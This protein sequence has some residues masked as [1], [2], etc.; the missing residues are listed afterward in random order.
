MVPIFIIRS[1]A[2][3]PS[4]VWCFATSSSKFDLS[5]YAMDWKGNTSVN[6]DVVLVM[7][8]NK[9]SPTSYGDGFTSGTSC[10]ILW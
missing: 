5:I 2:D 7:R 8:V 4:I 3:K 6:D 1:N 10:M 9:S